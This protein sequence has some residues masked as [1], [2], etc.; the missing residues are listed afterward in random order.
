MKLRR[1]NTVKKYNL[2]SKCLRVYTMLLSLM[3]G[4]TLH[5]LNV[6]LPLNWTI[7]EVEEWLNSYE[8]RQCKYLKDFRSDS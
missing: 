5:S 2:K 6:P 1:A 3:E 7:R 4:K 8:I